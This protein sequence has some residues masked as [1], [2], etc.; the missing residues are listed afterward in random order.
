VGHNYCPLPDGDSE[1]PPGGEW[2]VADFTPV[3]AQVIAI[4]LGSGLRGTE[5]VFSLA[6]K[7]TIPSKFFPTQGSRKGN[8]PSISQ[9]NRIGA[10][11]PIKFGPQEFEFVL[12]HS[13]RE[14]HHWNARSAD[15]SRSSWHGSFIHEGNLT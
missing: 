9:V 6:H 14:I 11:G 10:W 1:L 8:G 7:P 5:N 15:Y 3:M 2:C 4:Q 13:R 12:W